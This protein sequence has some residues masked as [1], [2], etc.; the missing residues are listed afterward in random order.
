MLFGVARCHKCLHNPIDILRF[1]WLHVQWR[2]EAP[3]YQAKM[4]VLG[5]RGPA[6]RA[7]GTRRTLESM[8]LLRPSWMHQQCLLWKLTN[9]EAKRWQLHRIWCSSATSVV[10]AKAVNIICTMCFQIPAI[11]TLRPAGLP[12]PPRFETF[13]IKMFCAKSIWQRWNETARSAEWVGQNP[14]FIGYEALLMFST[15]YAKMLS[16][17]PVVWKRTSF[18]RVRESPWNGGRRQVKGCV[19]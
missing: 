15:P 10:R 5:L 18:Q 7:A 9:D 12:P 3:S 8:S 19:G 17:A 1:Y 14:D 11:K 2:P 16:M 6:W 4:Q 13:F